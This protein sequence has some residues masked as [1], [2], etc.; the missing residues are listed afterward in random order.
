M[1]K[2]PI[3]V[4][5][6][7]DSLASIVAGSFDLDP[8]DQSLYIFCNKRHN[9]LKCL[10]YDG[11]GFWLFTKRIEEGTLK[12]KISE[13]GECP[14]ITSQQFRWLLEGLKPEQASA[15]TPVHYDWA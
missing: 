12:W 15:F 2:E 7:I 11:T 3:D 8:Y 6:G 13:D 5:K 14:E 10:Y 1:A 4:R 9:R